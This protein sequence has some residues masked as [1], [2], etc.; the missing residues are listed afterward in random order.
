METRQDRLRTGL[1]ALCVQYRRADA[2]AMD[3]LAV[4]LE[5][6]PGLD[7]E[8]AAW[9]AAHLAY[10]RVAPMLRA[11]RAVLR[12]L[13]PRPAHWLRSQDRELVASS[14]SQALEGWVWRFHTRED[15]VQWILAW[16]DLDAASGGRGLEPHLAPP[17]PEE[18]DARLSALVQRLRKSLPPTRGLRF[19]LPDPAEGAAAK[20]WRLFLRWMVR[21][22]WPDLGQWT[23]Y[24]ASA[25]V[26]PLDTHVARISIRL[27]LTDRKSQ[28]HRTAS[29]ITGALRAL[30]PADPLCCDFALSHLGILG[31]CPRDPSGSQCEG[32]LLVGLCTRL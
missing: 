3:P 12:P 16:K 11:I 19:C 31:D 9:V 28:D 25:L 32:C 2:L 8:V 14:L 20:R 5:F 22:E 10:G 30:F 6:E 7:R 1:A 13:G 24:P 29:A 23:T 18:A 26:I 4:V 21:P 27:G 17:V 15:L